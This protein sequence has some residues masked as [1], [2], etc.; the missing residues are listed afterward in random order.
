MLAAPLFLLLSADLPGAAHDRADAYFHFSLGLQARMVG[1]TEEALEQYRRAQKLD[2]ES[3]DIRLEIARLLRES[4]Q[5]AEAMTEARAAV[6]DS[7]DSAE[8]YRLLAELYLLTADREEEPDALRRAAEALEQVARLDT[9]DVETLQ[10]LGQIYAQ[11]QDH[12]AAASAWERLAALDPRSFEAQ[13]RAGR[14]YLALGDTDKAQAAFQRAMEL[15]PGSSA[16]ASLAAAYAAAQQTDQAVLYYR[17]ALELD[18]RSL[19]LH[20]TLGDVLYKARRYKEAVAEADAILEADASSPRGLD[21]KA[22][23]LRE[24]KDLDGALSAADQYLAQEPGSLQAAYLRVTIAE[25]RHDYA[26]AATGLERILARDRKQEDA[27]QAASNDRVFLV[28]LGYAY[29]RLSR[30][31]DAAEAFG[32]AKAV[33]GEP[34]A[35]LLGYRIDALVLAKDWDKALAESRAARTRFPEVSDFATQEATILRERGDLAGAL[36]I[37]ESLRQKNAKDLQ[38]LA[39]V[40]EFYQRARRFAD[41]ESVLRQARELEPKNLRVL[42]QLGAALERQ[43]RHED[44]EA[45]FREALVVQPDSA[46]LLNYLGYMNADRGVRV[47]EA[48]GLLERAV[49]LDPENGAYLDSLGWSLYRLGR[50]DEAEQKLRSALERSAE[51]AVILDHLADTLR[52]RGQLSE[53]VE[54]WRKALAG[55]DEDGELDRSG[56]ERKIREAQSALDAAKH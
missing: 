55:E 12:K 19:E 44:A 26:A 27:A 49:S 48:H 2:P 30:F 56:V 50:Y 21:L 16:Y 32:R 46:P 54:L 45:V 20:L 42:F 29:Q 18:P 34:D 22:R 14:S 33:G 4:G 9:D 40:A 11:L 7:P 25:A 52:S 47:D 38:V 36:K 41:A 3:A 13:L 28:H 17:K 37:V 15:R 10:R 51:N 8:G 1:D 6:A 23:A 5:P 31:A 24:L 43:K 39:E 35:A 53:A